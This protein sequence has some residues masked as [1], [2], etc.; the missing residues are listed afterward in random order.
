MKEVPVTKQDI[1]IFPSGPCVKVGNWSHLPS[2]SPVIIESNDEAFEVFITDEGQELPFKLGE[3][4]DFSR[5]RVE[6]STY[7][8]VSYK[9][10]IEK[11]SEMEESGTCSV[12]DDDT[13][14]KT[15]ADC[16]EAE[17]RQEFLP[18]LGC[19][20][21]WISSEDQCTSPVQINNT[22]NRLIQS[23]NL[24]SVFESGSG[25][26][27]SACN[28][29]STK[30]NIRQTFLRTIKTSSK[31]LLKIYFKDE[32]KHIKSIPAYGPLEFIVEVGSSLGLWL[33]LSIVGVFDLVIMFLREIDNVK[34]SVH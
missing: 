9:I 2:S 17:A 10:Q 18:L 34:K 22:Y 8:K 33:G 26:Q 6:N 16:V 20:I 15:Y 19:M 11:I 29:P 31:F 13:G 1:F 27:Y 25:M 30:R 21:P 7:P 28:A 5:I 24:W 14:Y 23:K 12:Y 3:F 4:S 32:V